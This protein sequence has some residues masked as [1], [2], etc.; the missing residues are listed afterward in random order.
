[1][2]FPW[3]SLLGVLPL[4]GAAVLMMVKGERAKSLGMV[5]SLATLVLG[6]VIAIQYAAGE[7]FSVQLPWI[8]AFGANYALGLDG[9]SLTMV[10]LT[11]VLTPFVLLASWDTVDADDRWNA[12]VYFALVL[13]LESLS[14]FV[15]LSTDVLLFYLFFEATL[16]PMYF[17]LG[18]FGGARRGYAAIKFLLFGLAGGLVML[19]AV[20]GLYVVSIRE[21]GRPTFL[22][23]DLAAL[24]LDGSLSRW[25]FLGFFI[26]FALKAPMV[27]AHTWLPDAAEHG[28]PGTS[29]LM[30]G[31][32]DKIGTFGMI[33]FCLELF[34]EASRWASPVIVVLALISIIYGALAAVGQKDIMRLIAFTS[35]S[36]FGFIVLGIFAFTSVS[37]TGATF[38]MFNH[39]FSTAVLF[40]VAGFL[41]QRRGTQDLR[42]FGG[43][44]KVA[45]V[46]AGL[47]L[48][49]G[50]SS[51]ALPGFSSFVSEFMVIAGSYARMPLVAGLSTVAMVL[52]AL[53]ILLTYQRTM[54]G[55]V[56]PQIARTF[57]AD[58]S[59]DL[60]GREK[61]A[62]APLL[63]IILA[64]GVFPKPM[65]DIIE[66]AVQTT[67]QQVDMADPATP[68]AKGSN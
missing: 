31:I 68:I 66:P 22:L 17:L 58:G 54:T 15:F 40:L 20:I 47:F 46:L 29:T 16:I 65:L 4:L 62:I 35:I 49:G 48:M 56:T 44:Q 3:L 25:L 12:H 43:V 41:V 55:P 9:I 45:P 63:I 2:S 34:P 10:L 26:A 32:L 18:G 50:L 27:P 30:V 38:Y 8:E 13:V 39:A 11:V 33:R 67:M 7:R 5:F 36:H 14:L 59:S 42:A 23:S 61:W 24:D 28:T 64:F 37:M 19:A 21:L 52:S 60:N 6:V 1:M 53:Y 51:L 57:A